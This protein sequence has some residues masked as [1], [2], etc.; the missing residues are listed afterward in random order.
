MHRVCFT[1]FLMFF[2]ITPV[3]AVTFNEAD[4]DGGDLSDN[5]QNPTVIGPGFDS[6]TA[7][8]NG[9]EQFDF[10]VFTNLPT[11]SQ[12]IDF[13][14]VPNT[15]VGDTEFSF[16]AGGNPRVSFD[17]FQ[18]EFDGDSLG[19]AQIV[20]NDQEETLSFLTPEDFEGVLYVSFNFTN[21]TNIRLNV[22]GFTEIP[23]PAGSVLLLTGIAAFAR[24]A[25]CQGRKNRK[26]A[27]ASQP[28]ASATAIEITP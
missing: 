3:A 16:N 19:N 2:S 22:Q 18:F 1:L 13:Q 12:Q 4:L 9:S 26:K 15:P 7:I 25:R 20:F 5:F 11:G 17:P 23:L 8:R 28:A 24:L 6:V 14:I 27:D 10:F 21:G